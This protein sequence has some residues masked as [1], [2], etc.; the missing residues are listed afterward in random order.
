MNKGPQCSHGIVGAAYCRHYEVVR[1]V[2]ERCLFQ[3]PML[4]LDRPRL[5]VNEGVAP[6]LDGVEEWR[7]RMRFY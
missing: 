6:P 7:Q 2:V 3:V 1:R 5:A 4:R